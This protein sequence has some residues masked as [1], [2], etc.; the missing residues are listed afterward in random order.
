MSA[1]PTGRTSLRGIILS[2]FPF[3]EGFSL[4]GSSPLALKSMT[5]RIDVQGPNGLPA[6]RQSDLCVRLA[7]YPG[8]PS[9]VPPSLWYSES[10]SAPYSWIP[11]A[12]TIVTGPISSAPGT[13]ITIASGSSKVT[14]G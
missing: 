1:V 8:I 5:G 13:A 11:V 4:S 14:I 6:A 12:V 9:S 3:L 10:T 2:L 7:F